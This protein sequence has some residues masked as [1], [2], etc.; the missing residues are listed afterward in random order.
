MGTRIALP[1]QG[2]KKES[3]LCELVGC[4]ESIYGKAEYVLEIGQ[5]EAESQNHNG[6]QKTSFKNSR[7]PHLEPTGPNPDLGLTIHTEGAVL[8]CE[9]EK[10]QEQVAETGSDFKVYVR[11]KG[12]RK[13]VAQ[14]SWTENLPVKIKTKATHPQKQPRQGMQTAIRGNEGYTA[15]SISDYDS[16]SMDPNS[17]PEQ[18]K[19]SQ[20]RDQCSNKFIEEATAQWEMAKDLGM[21][22]GSKQPKIIEKISSMEIIDRNN[23][24]LL[25]KRISSS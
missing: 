25:G 1:T 13:K 15:P 24:E 14:P 10:H 3:E 8:N 16:D 23:A 6:S 9:G 18:T 19:T 22:W 4:T 20:S 7:D 2:E 12:C 17:Q 21:T 5:K 11:A